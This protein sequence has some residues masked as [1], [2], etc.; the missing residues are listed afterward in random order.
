M[1]TGGPGGAGTCGPVCVT[2]LAN[3]S[4]P[5]SAERA[6]Q[7]RGV[8]IDDEAHGYLPGSRMGR[9]PCGMDGKLNSNFLLHGLCYTPQSAGT[10]GSPA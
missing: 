10:P 7:P 8:I 4:G 2:Q 5:V 3:C 1:P 6:G 9:A